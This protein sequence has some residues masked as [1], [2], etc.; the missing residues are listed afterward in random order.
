M[1]EAETARNLTSHE[2]PGGEGRGLRN[3]GNKESIGCCAASE[4]NT[5]NQNLLGP[6]G[7]KI[8]NALRKKEGLTLHSVWKRKKKKKPT[9]NSINV[10]KR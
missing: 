8:E 7:V 9:Q 5:A 2:G 4:I 1:K 10:R 6:L 3:K